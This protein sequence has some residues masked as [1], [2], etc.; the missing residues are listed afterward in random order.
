MPTVE[1]LIGQAR[2]VAPVD[3]QRK[4]KDV[5]EKRTWTRSTKFG[6]KQHQKND[7]TEIWFARSYDEK[8]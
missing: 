2:V 7:A 3:L 8:E 6:G 4:F 1:G 5:D